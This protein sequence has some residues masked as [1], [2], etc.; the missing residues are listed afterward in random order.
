MTSLVTLIPLVFSVALMV[1]IVKLAARLYRR[2][3]ISWGKALIYVMLMIVGAATLGLLGKVSGV[4]PPL[5]LLVVV[6]VSF[7][8][9]LAGWYLGSRA[10]TMDGSQLTF[11]RGVVLAL[12]A[13]GLLLAVLAIPA[14][15]LQALRP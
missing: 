4:A 14:L 15:I 8:T 13:F 10:Q 11:P 12:I 5:P 3:Q 6:S 9:L 1:S 2:T 7:H